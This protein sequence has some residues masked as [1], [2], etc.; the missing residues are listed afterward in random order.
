MATCITKE[1]YIKLKKAHCD[2]GRHRFR[3]NPFGITWCII[4]GQLSYNNL[5]LISKLQE[6]DKLIIDCIG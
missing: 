5:G 1:N 3:E 4:C 2:K 6:S